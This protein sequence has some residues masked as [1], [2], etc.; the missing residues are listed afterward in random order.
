MNSPVEPH[1]PLVAVQL[2]EGLSA[3]R[4]PESGGVYLKAADYWEWIAHRPGHLETL[5]PRAETATA[6]AA[7]DFDSPARICPETGVIMTRFRVGHGF[8][9]MIDRS[10][11]GGFWL[12]AGEWEALRE[13]TFH[14]EIHRIFTASW[15][16][17]VRSE[18]RKE[19]LEAQLRAQVGLEAY[20]R[21]A[22][23]RDWLARQPHRTRMLAWIS[24]PL[25][26]G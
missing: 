14:D 15:Q 18:A 26:H 3:W 19:A 10:P 9:F 22:E 6:A 7:E 12:D 20:Q 8:T 21:A 4:D 1:A 5:P 23:F 2:E 11:T 24:E 17:T 16:K 13:R 25:T